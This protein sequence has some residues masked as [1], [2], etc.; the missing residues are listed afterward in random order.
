MKNIIKSFMSHTLMRLRWSNSG[1]CWVAS[2]DSRKTGARKQREAFL[3]PAYILDTKGVGYRVYL[4][5]PLCQVPAGAE[6]A[7]L[8]E[9]KCE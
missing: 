1:L 9:I 6:S 3:R 4:K 8:I 5:R 7:S 2:V